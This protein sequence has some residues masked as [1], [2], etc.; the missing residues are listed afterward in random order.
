MA[1]YETNAENANP[2]PKFSVPARNSAEQILEQDSSERKR[3][4]HRRRRRRRPKIK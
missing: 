1:R 4:K 3:L 2:M